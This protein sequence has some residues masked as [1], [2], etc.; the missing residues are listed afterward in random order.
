MG[1]RVKVYDPVAMDKYRETFP[2]QGIIYCQSAEETARD[3]DAL[4]LLTDWDQF[5]HLNWPKI[6]STMRQKIIIDG[7]NM[8]NCEELQQEGFTYSGIGR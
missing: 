7:R 1:A 3:S 2:E 8:L 4:A 6:G 5:R